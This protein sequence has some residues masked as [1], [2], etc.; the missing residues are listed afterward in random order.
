MAILIRPTPRIAVLEPAPAMGSSTVV[1]PPVV[2]AYGPTKLDRTASDKVQVLFAA[3]DPAVKVKLV[4]LAKMVVGAK[5]PQP[6]PVIAPPVATRFVGKL[7]TKAG[8]ANVSAT[9]FGLVMTICMVALVLMF[10]AFGVND[11]TMVG[12]PNNVA[13]AGAVL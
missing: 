4:A 11:L 7:S 10:T 6:A 12:R 9:A 3:M 5:A 1:S 8:F 2:L 13:T